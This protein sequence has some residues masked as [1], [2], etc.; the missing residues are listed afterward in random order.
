[1]KRN[2]IIIV[3]L[4]AGSFYT[5]SASAQQLVL[6]QDQNP[7]Y[8]ES[9]RK[10]ARVADTLNS[11]HGTTIQD[12]YKAYDWYEA[13]QERRQQ[14]R[15]WRHEERLNG[16]Y[17]DYTPSWNVYGSYAYPFRYGNYGYGNHFGGRGRF[18]VGFGW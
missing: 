4:L 7:R 9:E 12:T 18:G 16:G 10:Y 11:Q 15:E 2:L 17:Y 8:R 1:M 5:I 13:R 6:A 3:S 14:N